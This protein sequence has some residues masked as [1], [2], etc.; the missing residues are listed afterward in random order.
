MWDKKE[1][2]GHGKRL[3]KGTCRRNV[4]K[5]SFLHRSVDTWNGLDEEVVQAKMIS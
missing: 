4:E 2:R 3:K 1:I 5:K